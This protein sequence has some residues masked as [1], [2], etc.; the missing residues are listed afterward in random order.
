MGSEQVALIASGLVA[1][2]LEL[3]PP[4]KR[5][6]DKLNSVQ[7]QL[8]IALIVLLVSAGSMAYSCRYNAECP[9][10]LEKVIVDM[11][12][13]SFFGLIGAGGVYQ[14][15]NYVGEKLAYRKAEDS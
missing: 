4:I 14:S 10:N 12:I 11:A 13:T 6:W 3:V 1:F 2:I 9:A 5:H 8:I 15:F 7:K